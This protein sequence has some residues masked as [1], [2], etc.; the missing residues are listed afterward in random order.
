MS[1][2][3]TRPLSPVSEDEEDLVIEEMP[4]PKKRIPRRPTVPQETVEEDLGEDT[5]A[6][7][8]P[9]IPPKKRKSKAPIVVSDE[10]ESQGETSKAKKPKTKGTFT[11]HQ[12]DESEQLWQRAMDVAVEILH[13]LKVD[14][15]DLT[16]LPDAG[17]VEC[18]RKACQAWLN[19]RKIVPTMTFTTQKTFIG[20]MARFL[21]DLIMREAGIVPNYNVSGCVVWN[22]QC[23][24]DMKCLHGLTMLN[25]EVV[26]EMDVGSENGQR[27]I[28]ETP[29]KAKIIT[30]RWGRSVVQLR[31]EDAL[32]CPHDA[33]SPSG[34]FNGKSCGVFYNEGA[35][36]QQAF[37][38]IMA[39]QKACYPK[40]EGATQRL[41]MPIKC[42]CNWGSQMCMLLGRQVCKMTPYAVNA[43][44][45]IDRT[46]VEDP[47]MLATVDH[48]SILVFQCCNPVY[49]N[50]KANPQKNCDFKISAPDV[51]SALQLA[52]Q[53]WLSIIPTPPPVSVQEFKW[54]VQY[55]YQNT[56]LP[57][58]Q[59]DNDESLF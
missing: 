19:E 17:T 22:H 38:Q 37:K 42:E 29:Q 51:I 54:G 6:L 49:R 27:A 50:S 15:K 31:N 52:K 34:V 11:H 5:Q 23:E 40:M 10:E 59:E 26:I 16:L 58:G 3:N 25:K 44:S 20:V 1:R 8:A 9:T 56:I 28:K 39:F 46:L 30:N 43:A 21:H 18:F 14:I 2:A 7:V 36:A 57:T 12:P 33:T 53:M 35:K 48:P 32:C 24:E 13:P 55:Q 41:L 45:N 47:K 4:K